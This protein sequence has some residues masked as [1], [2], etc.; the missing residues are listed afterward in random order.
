MARVSPVRVLELRSVRGTGGG[1]EKTIFSGAAQSDPQQ[2]AVTVCYIR[3]RRDT[4]FALDRIAADLGIDYVEVIERHSFDRAIWP[5]LRELVRS[6]RID[7]VHAHEYK[8]DLLAWLL[9]RAE[10]IRPLSTVHGWSGASVRETTVYYP[11]DRQLLRRF[12]T[13]IAVSDVIRDR[14]V[15]AGARPERVRT[16]LNGIDPDRFRKQPERVSAAR[17]A[18]QLPE[19]V[20]VLGAVGRLER[21]KRYDVLID[22]LAALRRTHPDALLIFAGEGSLAPALAAQAR[23]LGLANACV[24][25]GQCADVGDVFHAIDVFVQSSDT[26]GTPNAVLEAMALETPIVATAVGGTRD[27]IQDG[28]CGLLVPRRQ[29]ETL[30]AA[31]AATLADHAGSL[32]RVR[33]ARTRVER[34]LSFAA[35]MRAVERIYEELVCARKDVPAA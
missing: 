29:P 22:A 11:V 16:I 1:P 7:I 2:F 3:D 9:A 26:E 10:G 6:R 23:A 5:A 12:P 13:V 34:E 8:T 21:E 15:R 20:P 27:L 25:A 33:A 24:F 4:V 18:F 30:A 17:A 14:L 28:A 32:S 35:R 19:G 31:I